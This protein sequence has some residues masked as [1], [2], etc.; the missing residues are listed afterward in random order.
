MPVQVFI[1]Q[2]TEKATE[3]ETESGNW[4]G[5]REVAFG[6]FGKS[7]LSNGLVGRAANL[8]CC[9]WNAKLL[10]IVSF[11]LILYVLPVSND[12][13]RVHVHVHVHVHVRVLGNGY[14]AA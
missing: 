4:V 11:K 7:P 14:C 9:H 13:V 2:P 3:S 1:S 8:S 5:F 12:H 10:S 6:A